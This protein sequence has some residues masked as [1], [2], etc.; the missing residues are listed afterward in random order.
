[1]PRNYDRDESLVYIRRTSNTTGVRTAGGI[2]GN[3][4]YYHMASLPTNDNPRY[5]LSPD[6]IKQDIISSYYFKIK[7]GPSDIKIQTSPYPQVS[8]SMDENDNIVYEQ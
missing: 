7:T 2:I 4:E 6:N 3:W 5:T 1:M 8:G